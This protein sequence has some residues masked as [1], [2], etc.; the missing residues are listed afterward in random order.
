LNTRYKINV[1]PTFIFFIDGVPFE[2]DGTNRRADVMITWMRSIIDAPPPTELRSYEE[3][4][5]FISSNDLSILYFGK[6][7]IF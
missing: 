2:F 6:G 7:N 1:Y 5:D 4:N 3:I